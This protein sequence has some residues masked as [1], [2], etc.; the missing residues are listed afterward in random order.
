VVA[1]PRRSATPAACGSSPVRCSRS[2]TR[3][4]VPPSP[5]LLHSNSHHRIL[6]MHHYVV[7]TGQGPTRRARCG[8]CRQ[9][10]VTRTLVIDRW[11]HSSWPAVVLLAC[12][13]TSPRPRLSVTASLAITTAATRDASL[14]RACS[15][16]SWTSPS[17]PHPGLWP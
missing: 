2:T 11:L 10:K 14:V 9:G 5:P 13:S 8:T 7:L 6:Q 16:L 3:L 17:S 15:T 4:T 1:G 12:R